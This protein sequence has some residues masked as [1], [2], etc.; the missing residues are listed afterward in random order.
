[1]LVQ[2][3]PPSPV[4]PIDQAFVDGMD[5]FLLQARVSL[6]YHVVNGMDE[7]ESNNVSVAP[8]SSAT[9]EQH[10]KNFVW[11]QGAK[12]LG[13]TQDRDSDVGHIRAECDIEHTLRWVTHT[14]RCKHP[15]D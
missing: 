8:R 13:S 15:K 14:L 5:E 11:S 4:N 9:Q 1:M 2:T 6:T 7:R 12:H 10:S 3:P